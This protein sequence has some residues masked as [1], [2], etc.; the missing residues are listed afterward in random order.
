MDE[1]KLLNEMLRE[2]IKRKGITSY[3]NFYINKETEKI[4]I[5]YN[6][7]IEITIY[8]KMKLL[9]ENNVKEVASAL[10]NVCKLKMIEAIGGEIF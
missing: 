1:G 10:V 3:N 5:T 2:L 7:C 4:T 8:F 9:N 6:W